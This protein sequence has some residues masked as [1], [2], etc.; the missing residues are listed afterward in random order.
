[1][2]IEPTVGFTPTTAFNPAGT[3]PLPAVSVPSENVTSPHPTTTP[4]PD[5]EPPGMT[6]P[7]TALIG[8]PYG[9]LVP[10]RPAANWSMF[11]L[12]MQMHPASSK[13]RTAG[14][15]CWAGYE[16][17]GHAA[18]VWKPAT[19]ML[20]FTAKHAPHR[21]PLHRC[22]GGQVSNHIN[23]QLQELYMLTIMATAR[24]R[25]HRLSN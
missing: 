23:L 25:Q 19:S 1:M 10:L 13:A 3:R 5:D 12:P 6:R 9:D 4:E 8:T 16:N 21:G 2:E 24:F 11:V 15:L 18:V 22:S 20:S 17:S 14:A 7:S